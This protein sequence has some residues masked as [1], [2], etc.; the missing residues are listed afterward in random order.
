MPDA[1][2]LLKK[3]EYVEMAKKEG[4][5]WW[6]VG[7]RAILNSILKRHLIKKDNL[8][9]DVG[10]GGG[11]NILFLSNFGSVTGLDASIDAINFC[12]NKGF[13]NL[14]LGTAE[15]TSCLGNSFDVV[16]AFDV[17]EHLE[18]DYAALKEMKRITKIGGLIM[19]TVPA[20]P[21]LWNPQ[22]DYL[23]HKRRYKKRLLM[24]K[25]ATLELDILEASYFIIPTI[26]AIILRRFLEKV[27]KP[28]SQPHSFDIIWP[29]W[30]NY[31]LIC[32][33]KI[34][35]LLLKI[36]PAPFGSSLY[37]IAKKSINKK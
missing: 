18:D 7:R 4:F 12:K 32:W 8:I 27:F 20:L 19:V 33:L 24:E 23:T 9:L 2:N 6:H 26:P 25:F 14:I 15:N 22:D 30:L 10:C 35:G 36:L 21:F 1:L 16:T 34:E 29:K 13:K 17:L 31:I 3:E 5:Y 28:D 11:G 37:V